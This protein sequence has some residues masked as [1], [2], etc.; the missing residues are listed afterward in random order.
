MFKQLL[1]LD[2]WICSHDAKT[3]MR[4]ARNK[5][6]RAEEELEKAPW[7]TDA[8]KRSLSLLKD[9]CLEAKDAMLLAEDKYTRELREL[10]GELAPHHTSAQPCPCAKACRNSRQRS[11][12]DRSVRFTVNS[13]LRAPGARIVRQIYE[14]RHTE[15]RYEGRKRSARAAITVKCKW[16]CMKVTVIIWKRYYAAYTNTDSLHFPRVSS[17]PL[18]QL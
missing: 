8:D 16:R 6:D 1:R 14:R 18:H 9:S 5:Y 10:E 15:G 2:S 3:S 4:A 12:Q 17:Y 11:N 7:A 13:S